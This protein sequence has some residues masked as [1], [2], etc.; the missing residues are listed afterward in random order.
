MAKINLDNF[1]KL[2]KE[3]H[4]VHS[5][6]KST[7]SIFENDGEKYFQI[8]TYGKD[9]RELKDKISQSIQLNKDDAIFLVKLLTDYFNL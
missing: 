1:N 4:S 6:V 5:K 8:D 3:R 7:Y 2:D 9:N